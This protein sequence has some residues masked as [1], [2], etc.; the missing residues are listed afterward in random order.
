MKNIIITIILFISIIILLLE[1]VRLTFSIILM[2]IL[3]LYIFM[4]IIEV[5]NYFRKDKI[6]ESNKKN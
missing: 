6:N 1:P 5:N 3:A 2:K 4:K